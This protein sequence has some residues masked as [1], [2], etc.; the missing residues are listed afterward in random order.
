MSDSIFTGALETALEYKVYSIRSIERI[1]QNML[2]KDLFQENNIP[3]NSD[4]QSREEYQKG[5]FSSE[6]DLKSFQKLIDKKE[7]DNE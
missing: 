4:Y 5:R 2:Q 1:A 6:T 3:F 7:E